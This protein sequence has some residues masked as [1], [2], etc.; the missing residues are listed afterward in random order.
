MTN[1][2]VSYID[3]KVY[4]ERAEIDKIGSKNSY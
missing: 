4:P 3:F 2:E 1:Y